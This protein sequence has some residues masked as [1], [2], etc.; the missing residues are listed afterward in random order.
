MAGLIDRM[1]RAAKLDTTLYEEVESDPAATGQAA[2]VVA[3]SA[4]AAAIGSI[5]DDGGG[6]GPFGGL[7][8][9]LLGWV[10]WAFLCHV[11]GTKLLP[12]ATTQSNLGELLRT[13]GFAASPGILRVLGGIPVLGWLVN[14]IAALW[15][16]AAFV[17]A[18]R[19]ALDYRSTGRAVAVV[20]LAYAIQLGFI[21]LLGAAIFGT[22]WTL[23]GGHGGGHH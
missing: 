16:L 4:V 2:A 18:V 15:M 1:I 7:F 9:A 10:V 21:L 14:V 17:I 5:G 22:A 8:L 12:E 19:Q 11:L 13:T 23:F 20:V 6:F 3:I